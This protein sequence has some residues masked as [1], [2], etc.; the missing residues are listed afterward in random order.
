MKEYSGAI[1]VLVTLVKF[2]DDPITT[3]WVK[4]VTDRRTD[5]HGV[6][7]IALLV[8]LSNQL[9]KYFNEEFCAK[10]LKLIDNNINMSFLKEKRTYGKVILHRNIVK[11]NWN[12]WRVTGWP[13]IPT[14][15][16]Q[17]KFVVTH[18]K[19]KINTLHNW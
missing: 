14:T 16:I 4:C 5:R 13:I 17:N 10:Q 9:S 12:V 8:T 1:Q 2:G 19:P 11:V 3:F 18:I 15:I 6:I 7:T